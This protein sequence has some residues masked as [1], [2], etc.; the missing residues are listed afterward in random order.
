[1]CYHP[2]KLNKMVLEA[3][4][5]WQSKL[6]AAVLAANTCW[7]RSTKFTSFILIYGR[8]ANSGHLL[9]HYRSV[10]T[11][12]TNLRFVLTLVTGRMIGLQH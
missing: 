12:M 5:E 6:Q 7:K 9:E 3:V 11:W 2:I 1:M 10:M 4:V 8:E